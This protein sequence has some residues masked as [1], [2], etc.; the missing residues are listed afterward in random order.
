MLM[1]KI[2][3][4]GV[5][6]SDRISGKSTGQ[7]PEIKLSPF[8]NPVWSG[9][10]PDSHQYETSGETQQFAAAQSHEVLQH[11]EQ[12]NISLVA[13]S[14]KTQEEV[15]VWE[16]SLPVALTLP[17]YIGSP[18]VSLY[19]PLKVSTG[20]R[21]FSSSLQVVGQ[22]TIYINGSFSAPMCYNSEGDH[23]WANGNFELKFQADSEFS[24]RAIQGQL[25][26]SPV[27]YKVV[28][29]MKVPLPDME[30]SSKNFSL[31]SPS[32]ED[33]ILQKQ[34]T[35]SKENF[36]L[37]SAPS[38][39]HQTFVL[40]QSPKEVRAPIFLEGQFSM[41]RSEFY[42]DGTAF[43]L[44]PPTKKAQEESANS[45][46]KTEQ[47]LDP[48]S[49]ENDT[50]FDSDWV[51][52]PKINPSKPELVP[53]EMDAYSPPDVARYFESAKD[54]LLKPNDVLPAVDEVPEKKTLQRSQLQMKL[55]RDFQNVTYKKE[56]IPGHHM[57]ISEEE[58]EWELV[59]GTIS[60]YRRKNSTDPNHLGPAE[61]HRNRNA[62]DDYIDERD[63]RMRETIRNAT[64]KNTP[65]LMARHFETFG[66]GPLKSID[67]S[68]N[69]WVDLEVVVGKNQPEANF[70]EKKTLQRSQLQMKLDRDFQNVTY[71]K[72]SIPGHHMNIS[73]EESEW[74]L[75]P[76]TIS[77]YRRKNSTDPNH[78]GPAEP[79][80]NRNAFDDH[81][82][83]ENRRMREHIHNMTLKTA[84]GLSSYSKKS[85]V[86]FKLKVT[87]TSSED[88][89]A[90]NENNRILFKVDPS[91]ALFPMDWKFDILSKV[92][93]I[94]L[95]F[96]YKM[97]SS[98]RTSKPVILWSAIINENN[99]KGNIS[100]PEFILDANRQRHVLWL[101]TT[102]S[103][104]C[105]TSAEDALQNFATSGIL[106]SSRLLLKD[107]K[108]SNVENVSNDFE[109]L[110]WQLDTFQKI[111]LIQAGQPL[112]TSDF[113]LLGEFTDDKTAFLWDGSIMFNF[114]NR[115]KK[116]NLEVAMEDVNPDWSVT[117]LK[118]TAVSFNVD[119]VNGE[120]V[121]PVHPWSSLTPGSFP[122]A[123]FTN[124]HV[125]DV[126]SALFW[127]GCVE[128]DKLKGNFTLPLF[129]TAITSQDV[130]RGTFEMRL[131]ANL[132]QFS[133][134]SRKHLYTGPNAPPGPPPGGPPGPMP[135]PRK[136]KGPQKNAPHNVQFV[137]FLD[138]WPPPPTNFPK[139]FPIPFPINIT[140]SPSDRAVKTE[141]VSNLEESVSEMVDSDSPEGK[142]K[143]PSLL[144]WSPNK[145][146]SQEELSKLIKPSPTSSHLV[147]NT[148]PWPPVY[149][150]WPSDKPPPPWEQPFPFADSNAEPHP[151]EPLLAKD[152]ELLEEKANVH[153]NSKTT[154]TVFADSVTLNPANNVKKARKNVLH[155]SPI[156]S[157]QAVDCEIEKL[158]SL[159]MKQLAAT[160]K[161]GIQYAT[162]LLMKSKE[163]VEYSTQKLNVSE[164]VANL[165]K[166]SVPSKIVLDGD[167]KENYD[168][169]YWPGNA[170]FL[171]P[172]TPLQKPSSQIFNKP[173]PPATILQKLNDKLGILP[174]FRG[175]FPVRVVDGSVS[176]GTTPTV[177]STMWS[178]KL[179]LS[180]PIPA[181]RVS[182]EVLTDSG[183]KLGIH[184]TPTLVSCD[185]VEGTYYLDGISN[186]TISGNFR[187][188]MLPVWGDSTVN[189]VLTAG[190]KFYSEVNIEP[191]PDR[192]KGDT[193]LQESDDS[194]IKVI[195]EKSV[196]L[197]IKG[198]YNVDSAIFDW[199]G[200]IA[201]S[202][203]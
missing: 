190:Q 68:V 163:G 147:F 6:Y 77:D 53:S 112:P 8:G 193:G 202:I 107:I 2:L 168:D 59:P 155:A 34:P 184:W 198:D 52:V 146:L 189:K 139:M 101:N 156:T 122:F 83:E 161:P 180:F 1:F 30:A 203:P 71:K 200:D 133:W 153:L 91:I 65:D 37:Q 92:R 62:L 117:P 188:Q 55:D 175:F 24:W 87:S 93:V 142:G 178:G 23:C 162:K 120:P 181:T 185:Q 11:R 66:N 5:F 33:F 145:I 69:E 199:T 95:D 63:R 86:K 104:N 73:D 159:Y 80:R 119:S 103:L 67:P 75:V 25:M 9:D 26:S 174:W 157:K 102:F 82:D 21:W 152:M 98:I 3:F 4:F 136:V 96:F 43:V 31:E 46:S 132:P 41:N 151:D 17:A 116:D 44:F 135:G 138:I 164:C 176:V 85:V 22:N 186:S 137:P 123:F 197:T 191:L 154:Q 130:L 14:I 129:P 76:G 195:G 194:Q 40:Q 125:A 169:Y 54:D 148:V 84:P 99:L 57:N 167:W 166:N 7:T 45:P 74:E 42:W 177:Q 140:A 100:I 89:S 115:W 48:D 38:M 78:L 160:I 111:S 165:L 110:N 36:I 61:P 28:K 79:H 19:A 16:G 60:D 144:H 105:R 131:R 81:V 106:H 124:N 150:K 39:F 149:P 47:N 109:T 126:N 143:F 10:N 179:P 113:L 114:E 58:S 94:P 134:Y 171:V 187:F 141:P 29:D 118:I 20:I 170:V 35:V 192:M 196:P 18:N 127:T 32:A 70:Q 108:C 97:N 182:G 12:V 51:I 90:S 128:G 64:L 172:K 72:E 49:L 158:T 173:P 27:Y 56:S 13:G 121:S 183:Y 50:G 201:I 15:M 88:N